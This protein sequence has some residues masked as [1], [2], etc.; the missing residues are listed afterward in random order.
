[1][2]ASR[3]RGGGG[4]FSRPAA[5]RVSL[6]HADLGDRAGHVH[7]LRDAHRFVS[8]RPRD[9]RAVPRTRSTDRPAWSS[10]RSL[11]LGSDP[12][13]TITTGAIVEGDGTH[14]LMLEPSCTRR[15]S[16][17]TS[18][19]ATPR[20]GSRT[21][22][23]H[24]AA[25]ASSGI[26]L[27]V[28]LLR[29]DDELSASSRPARWPRVL[30]PGFAEASTRIDAPSTRSRRAALSP[31][32]ALPACSSSASGV[33]AVLVE[34]TRARRARRA[35]STSRARRPRRAAP[36]N[37]VR[38]T[39]GSGARSLLRIDPALGARG[40]EVRHRAVAI[41]RG[42]RRHAAVVAVLRGHIE[43]SARTAAGARHA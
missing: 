19:R 16:T 3:G 38:C 31:G 15:P 11:L 34:W 29:R 2:G 9:V 35:R 32:V 21:S 36:T 5:L 25:M 12:T 13:S 23:I 28:G 14:A 43:G 39:G 18:R 7:A 37:R 42:A 26:D 17:A 41:H 22:S 33:G 1:M 40:I 30:A 20:S 8:A 27:P 4:R 6:R 10:R 24:S